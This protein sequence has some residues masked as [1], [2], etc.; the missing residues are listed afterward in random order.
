VRPRWASAALV[1]AVVAALALQSAIVIRTG[2]WLGDFKAFY[3]AARVAAHGNDPYR[4]QPLGQCERS[5]GPTPFFD[6]HRAVTIPAPL[7]G[8][9]IA[10]L[11]PLA[12]LSFPA[13]AVLWLALLAT[14]WIVSIAALAKIGG[15]G[16]EIALAVFGLSLGVLSLPFGEV[17]PI[18]IAC[19][20]AA[21]YF[22]WRG[23][24][25]VAAVVAAGAMIE[26]HLGLP[27]C[28]AMA[29][30]LPRTRL[31]LALCAAVLAFVSIG[32]LGMGANAEYF[33]SVLPAHALSEAARDTQFSL[34]AVLAALGLS[35]QFAVRGGAISY[36]AMLAAGVLVA[37]YLAKKSCND[38]FVVCIPPAFAVFGGTFIHITQIAAALP[39]ALL[40]V[41]HGAGTNRGLALTVLLLL[42]V[43]WIWAISPALL[44]APFVPVGYLVARYLPGN[45]V[46]VLVAAIAAVALLFGLHE[47]AAAAPHAAARA[48]API[49]AKLAE[50]SWSRFA[51]GSSSEALAAWLLRLPTWIGLLML[52][53]TSI[54]L[55]V[56][57]SGEASSAYRWSGSRA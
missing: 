45:R 51:Q 26:P 39:A 48:A 35:Q 12:S 56:M 3:C 57:P 27:V 34:T 14:A 7:P 28:I 21:A 46:V 30:W 24:A 32:A 25:T 47:L 19:I 10:A 18:A 22:A 54:V 16:W 49:D 38:A 20:T 15:V 2:F 13:A 43:P 31:P 37:G 50:A 9:A 40:L 8:Y 33:A 41:R 52:A 55:T 44:V 1:L 17:V 4:A 11:F 6:K 5:L 42:A 23:R 29:V 36:A 53:A